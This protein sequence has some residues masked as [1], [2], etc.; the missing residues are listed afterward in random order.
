MY[1][2]WGACG[3][4]IMVSGQCV[5]KITARFTSDKWTSKHSDYFHTETSTFKL[6]FFKSHGY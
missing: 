4:I 3:Q 2:P 1:I 6:Q 5:R